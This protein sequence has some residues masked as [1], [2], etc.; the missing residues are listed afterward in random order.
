[1]GKLIFLLIDGLSYD[2]AILCMSYLASLVEAGMAR[3]GEA[4][5]ILPPLSRP[6]YATFLSGKTPL[7]HSVL[8]NCFDH[9]PL[10]D[11][12]FPQA[13]RGGL[14]TAAAAYGWFFELCVGKKFDP[15]QHRIW[16]QES[17]PIQHGLFYE[18]DN[19]PDAE[20]FADGE[21]LRLLWQPD[22]LLIH[23]MGVDWAGHLHGGSSSAYHDAARKVDGILTKYLPAW[24]AVGYTVLICSDHG[25]NTEGRHYDTDTMS[26][27]VPYWL[28]GAGKD[29]QLPA[30]PLHMKNFILSALGLHKSQ[31]NE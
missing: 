8:S 22:L 19:Y 26:R 11:S 13:G 24:L 27:R 14:I 16:N 6:A 1:M 30:S 3:L 12:F 10:A 2:A 20:L 17:S 5:A 21:A 25:M 15:A 29:A 23:P 28:I 4:Q 9:P 18:S 31:K 7:A